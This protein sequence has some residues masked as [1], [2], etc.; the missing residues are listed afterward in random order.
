MNM[1][2]GM[3]PEIQALLER[4]QAMVR[5]VLSRREELIP[6]ASTYADVHGYSYQRLG[7]L[8][9]AFEQGVA[10]FE[11][12]FWQYMGVDWCGVIP[13]GEA[14][15]NQLFDFV[16]QVSTMDMTSDQLIG[17]FEPYFY[18]S[19]TELG[20]PSVPT[21]NIDE[22]LQ[23][24]SDIQ[25]YVPDGQVAEFSDESM[26]DIASWVREQATEV[27]FIYGEYDPWTAGAF[28]PEDNS[29]VPVFVAD[30]A[31]H[32]ASIVHLSAAD[33]A[34]VS[35]LLE[36]WTSAPASV[37]AARRR[38]QGTS[39]QVVHPRIFARGLR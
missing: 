7:G 13:G 18:Q 6:L 30:M 38:S 34:E 35:N 23:Y 26:L 16:N 21:G 22:L 4:V 36:L 24:P 9:A 2:F 29:G 28:D 20:Y 25:S 37:S 31:D 11:W 1:N 32:G 10:E 15:A 3:R 39:G 14:A 12:G 17:L 8:D 33:E 19:A 27:M 5:D